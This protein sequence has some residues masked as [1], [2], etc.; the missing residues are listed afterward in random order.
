MSCLGRYVILMDEETII[1]TFKPVLMGIAFGED[2]K[3]EIRAQAMLAISDLA[4]MF[5]RIMA[6]IALQNITEEEVLVFYFF[7]GLES[8]VI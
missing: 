3:I 6:P 1:D 2:E 4:F 8:L 7:M 5:H